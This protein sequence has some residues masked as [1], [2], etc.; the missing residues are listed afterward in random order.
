MIQFFRF[1]CIIFVIIL[2]I[3]ISNSCSF[4][5]GKHKYYKTW[6]VLPN[7]IL[8]IRSTSKNTFPI[9]LYNKSIEPKSILRINMKDQS[10]SININPGDSLKMTMPIYKGISVENKNDLDKASFRIVIYEHNGHI[11]TRQLKIN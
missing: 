6:D 3:S 9:V 10:Y 11:K 8:K 1:L 7:S 5:R 2:H 4:Q